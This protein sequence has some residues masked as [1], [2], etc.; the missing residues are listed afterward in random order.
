MPNL[1]GNNNVNVKVTTEADTSGVEKTESALEGLGR[2]GGKIGGLLAGA[3]ATGAAAAAAAIVAVGAAAAGA[4]VVGFKFNASVESATATINAFTKDAGKTAEIMAFV[5]E[6]SLKTQFGFTDMAEAASGLIP[7]SKMSGVALKDLIKQA[8]ILGALNPAEGLTGGAF[9]L[10]EALSGD[11][12]SIVERFNL[13]RT[14]L[15]QLKAEGVPAMQAIQTALKE[16]GIDY[17]LVAAQGATTGARWD[18][19]KDQFTQLS[20]TISKPIFDEVSKGLNRLSGSIDFQAW[21]EKG[22]RAMETLMNGL[23]GLKSAYEGEGITSDG[24]VGAMER[25]GVVIRAAVLGVQALGAAFN[26]EG[27]TSDGFVGKMEQL[28]VVLRQI[29]D[30]VYAALAPSFKSLGDTIRNDL[31]PL[32]QQIW[33]IL[34]P[35]LLPVLKVMAEIIGVTL[36]G[37]IWLLVNG[38]NAILTAGI[39]VTNFF[40]GMRDVFI[41]VVGTIIGLWTT[42][43]VTLRA[44]AYDL[45][46]MIT[47]PFEGAYNYVA[48]LPDKMVRLF[49]NIGGKIRQVIGDIDIPGPLG[50]VKDTI[51]GFASGGYTGAGGVNE[52]AGIVHRGE[53]VV[54]KNQV[55]QST[56]MP[57]TMGGI[58]STT[59]IGTVILNTKEAAQAFAESLSIDSVLAS[60]GLA[61]RMGA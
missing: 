30:I 45:G 31:I 59:T 42:L 40:I 9:A 6:E 53:Y 35:G 49:A 2:T 25:V 51:P 38:L 11:F 29:W 28:G 1:S 52:V 17:S 44:A 37:A 20:G 27:V 34:G 15:N 26:G 18:T 47:A 12:T 58:S 7:A 8:E 32:W 43:P 46:R 13:P 56:G 48:T 5:K 60:K 54:P 22:A 21:G 41:N 39:A 16:M 4:T 23:K 24:F 50:K 57:K 3:A 14:R 55:D 61:T 19:L 36:I 10:K 33:D